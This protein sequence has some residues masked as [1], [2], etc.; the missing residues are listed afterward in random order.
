[1][2]VQNEAP[3]HPAV[4]KKHNWVGLVL[5]CI[6]LL[7]LILRI[8]YLLEIVNSPGFS[9]PQIDAGY[10]DYWARALATGDWTVPEYFIN[11]PEIRVNP[12]IRPPGY[13][14][15]LAFVY[16]LTDGSYLAARIVQMGLGL[17][18]CLL[19]FLLGR[20]LFGRGTGLIF[21]AFMSA[22]WVF[23]YFEGELLA[24]VLLVTLGLLLMVLLHMWW[25]KFT[26]W[27]AF[28]AGAG[29]G[30]FALVRPNILLFG[31]VVLGWCWWVARRRNSDRSIVLTWLGFLL[32]AAIVISPATIRNYIVAHDFVI[33]TSNAG[34]NLY[35]ANNEDSDGIS[36]RIPIL[37]KFSDRDNW[38]NFDYAEIVRSIEL[39]QGR[40]MKHSEVSAFFTRQAVDYIKKNPARILRLMARKAALFWGPMAV[41][42]NEE[43]H[44]EKLKSPTLRYI[45]GFPIAISF[46]IVG[47][48]Q[49]FLGRKERGEPTKALT[50]VTQR[51]FEISILVLLFILTY[52]ISYLPFVAAERYRVPIIPFLFLFGAYGLFRIGQLFAFRN[53]YRAAGWTVICIGLYMAASRPLVSYEPDLPRWHFSRACAYRYAKQFDK[54]IEECHKAIRL[55]PDFIKA[56]IELGNALVAQGRLDEAIEHYSAALRIRPDYA[57]AHNNMGVAFAVQGKLDKAIDQY[58]EALRIRPDSA[59]THTELG[60][61]LVAQGRLDEAIDHYSVAL[62]IRPDYAKAHNNLGLALAEH[63]K[64][65]EAIGHYNEA[66]RIRPDS[67]EAHSN[68][69]NALVAQGRLDEAIDHYSTALRIKPDSVEAHNNLGFALGEQGRTAEAISHYSAALRIRPDYAKALNNLGHAL[70][71]QGEIKQAIAYLREAVRIMPDSADAQHNLN[72]ALAAQEKVDGAI[73]KVQEALKVD[74]RNPE[75]HCKLGNLYKKNL[76]LGKA[77]DQYQKTLSLQPG[78]VQALNNLAVVYTI[79]GE[80][81]KALSGFKTIINLRPDSAGTYYNIACIYARQDRTK[82]SVDW[83]NMAIERGYKNWDLIKT[84]KDLENIRDSS[85]FKKIIG[86][87]SG[88]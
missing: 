50:L 47:I 30:L 49:L 81:D 29:V 45:P 73:G 23:I 34:L 6:L 39:L 72:M 48:L 59:E 27:R 53:L 9:F 11:D 71:R 87:N 37:K 10:H 26:F 24:P 84:D 64:T 69:G 88:P 68:L 41:A 55:N 66:L 56:Y 13:P 67:A 78:N 20:A 25:K 57:K 17:V 18:N 31:P 32:G 40:K 44:Y 43:L 76:D 16:W 22:Y 42:C 36:P 65:T 38:T 70:V 86:E 28:A 82:E 8:S 5:G 61:V 52:F 79:Q 4:N 15:F 85:T 14:F 75:L 80:Y 1:M 19:A 33:I 77:I 60:N 51:Q 7:G 74:P 62:R 3:K 58:D 21:A 63:G 54:V 2:A 46:A 12:Y 35:I 83:L